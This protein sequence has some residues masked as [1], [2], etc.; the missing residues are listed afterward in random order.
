M[1]GQA[2]RLTL[3]LAASL[4][5]VAC[6]GGSSP[7][8]TPHPS[9]TGAGFFA[10]TRVNG[11]ELP[12]Q[13]STHL[14]YRG[15]L[16]LDT[17]GNYTRQVNDSTKNITGG[18]D[19]ILSQDHGTWESHGDSV[20]MKTIF[21]QYGYGPAAGVFTATGLTLRVTDPTNRNGPLLLEFTRSPTAIALGDRAGR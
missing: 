12:V 16:Q 9:V 8:E 4:A 1:A 7:T 19:R 20:F 15:A 3:A 21:G 6:G 5:L 10:M 14:W 2:G 17:S 18:W 11:E 13:V